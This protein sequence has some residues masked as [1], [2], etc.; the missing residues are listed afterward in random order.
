[1]KK[2]FKFTEK[3]AVNGGRT[4]KHSIS[5]G[6]FSKKAIYVVIAL[7][8][9]V[10]FSCKDDDDNDN[11]EGDSPYFQ[12]SGH[13]YL[14]VKEKKTWSAASADATAKG[15]Y[16]VE[17]NNLEEQN[18]IYDTIKK[19]GILTT[20]V[21]VS[22]GGGA[23]YIWIGA[24]DKDTEGEWVW[25]GSNT[26]FWSGTGSGSAVDNKY[27]NWGGKKA[28]STNEP[29]NYGDAGQDAAAIGLA[30]WPVGVD[31][32]LGVAGE[33]NDIAET[34]TLYYIIEFDEVKK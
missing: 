33:W 22:D 17:I 13:S 26:K 5:M 16:L 20:Y 34:N 23:A 12:H 31:T 9:T 11:K 25:K 15:G 24:S 28:G 21:A 4:E 19:S 1:M 14:I 18:A 7:C 6:T 10:V 32:E 30:K 2:N 3:Y 8:M 27:H 29:D